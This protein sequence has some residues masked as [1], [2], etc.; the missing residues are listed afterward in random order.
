VTTGIRARIDIMLARQLGRPAG[1]AGR[2]VARGLNRGN[3]QLIEAAVAALPGGPGAA[4]ADV[5]FGGGLG[6]RLLLA[7]PDVAA[8]HGVEISTT[9]LDRARAEFAPDVAGGRLHLHESSMTALPM[10]AH[11]L[12]GI[13]SVNTIYFIDDLD[14]AVG[15]LARTLKGS[16]RA[17]LGVGDPQAME[18]M[19][20]TAHGFRV[21]P[22]EVI[23]DTIS[24]AGLRLDE[25]RR[26]GG[27]RISSHLLVAGR[28][29]QQLRDKTS[30]PLPHAS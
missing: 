15:E 17:V 4:L 1:L 24:G 13:L 21:R 10:T 6:L 19:S 9:M 7:R 29:E 27:G 30:T 8:V 22:I 14:S 16:G 26:V 2:L 23:E 25:H 3:R 12:D 5:G 20:F 11:S 28:D 18:G